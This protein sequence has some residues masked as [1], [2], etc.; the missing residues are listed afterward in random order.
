M[1]NVSVTLL[2]HLTLIETVAVN[3][4]C[5]AKYERLAEYI[6]IHGRQRV[7]M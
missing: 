7:K 5:F 6:N 4:C 2:F 3:E 1:S